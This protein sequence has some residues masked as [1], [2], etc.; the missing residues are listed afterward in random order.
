MARINSTSAGG[1]VDILKFLFYQRQFDTRASN[2]AD[3]RTF[4]IGSFVS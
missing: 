1:T 2:E 4:G 3:A